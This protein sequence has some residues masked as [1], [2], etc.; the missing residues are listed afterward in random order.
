MVLKLEKAELIIAMTYNN[1]GSP[2]TINGFK[3]KE[4][5]HLCF[6]AKSMGHDITVIIEGLNELE[7]ILEVLKETKMEAPN[8]GLRVR[9]HEAV[10]VV[11][12]QKSGGIDSKIWTYFNRNFRSF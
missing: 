10:E 8:V 11:F 1:M 4:M 7:M 12:G 5:I 2:I 6:I 3:D 9:L